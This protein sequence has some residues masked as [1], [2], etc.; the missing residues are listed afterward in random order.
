[1]KLLMENWRKFV[2]EEDKKSKEEE[3]FE[4]HMMYDPETG[5]GKKA[6]KYE[7]HVEM[8]KK[9]WGHEKPDLDEAKNEDGKEQG[10]DGKAC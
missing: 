4:P 1:M 8:D 2:N 3:D 6:E 9:G 5:E 10:V 7:D